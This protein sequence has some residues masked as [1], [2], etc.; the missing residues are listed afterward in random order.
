MNETNAIL[1]ISIFCLANTIFTN[2]N[3]Q[4]CISKCTLFL[5]EVESLQEFLMIIMNKKLN[6]IKF[7][8]EILNNIISCY[9]TPTIMLNL[10]LG[11]KNC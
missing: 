10:F 4:N 2:K 6:P 5:L 3:L 1:W 8:G 11:K 9:T 7:N